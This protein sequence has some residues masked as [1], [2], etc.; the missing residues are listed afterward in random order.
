MIE[1]KYVFPLLLFMLLTPLYG[2]HGQSS[3]GD[4]EK[5]YRYCY[6]VKE[7][8]WY[9]KQEKLW[10]IEIARNPHN[11]DAW[12]NCFFAARYGWSQIEGQ[13]KPR[14]ALLD[15]IYNEMGQA[16][17]NSWVY[18]Y[19]HY[20]NYGTDFTRL[21]KAYHINPQKPDLYWEFMKEY[22]LTGDDKKKREF[23]RKLYESKGNIKNENP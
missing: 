22:E 21:E 23:C 1:K 16:I 5:V 10:S 13:T 9:K 12:Y 18:H 3:Q 4:P 15:S 14:E 8:E 2:V 6:V 17:P 7:K 19:I 11:E 20:Y